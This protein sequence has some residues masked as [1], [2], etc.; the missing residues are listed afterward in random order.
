MGRAHAEGTDRQT[1]PPV[2]SNLGESGPGLLLTCQ[3]SVSSSA[4]SADAPPAPT[5]EL[6]SALRT[7]NQVPPARPELLLSLC[8]RL[9]SH[10]YR[11]APPPALETLN[12]FP[13]QL[14]RAVPQEAGRAGCVPP[15]PSSPDGVRTHRSS[16]LPCG[17]VSILRHVPPMSPAPSRASGTQQL[18]DKCLWCPARLSLH[19]TPMG[20]LSGL[21]V[22]QAEHG[23]ELHPWAVGPRPELAGA[24]QTRDPACLCPREHASTCCP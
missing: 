14:R 11:E 16:H 6:S 18:L 2:T 1:R 3:R 20:L 10:S 22:P 5:A 17:M 24:A 9:S 4:E 19:P 23:A 15:L 21:R 12:L 8:L 13:P 7:P